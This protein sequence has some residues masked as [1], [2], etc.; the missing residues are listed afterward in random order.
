MQRPAVEVADI[1]RNFGP[2]WLEANRGHVSHAQLKVM[3][4]ILAC[5][6]AA[7]GGFVAI[8]NSRLISADAS[9]V[10]FSYKDYRLEGPEWYTTMTLDPGEFI[11]RF[12]LH[13]LPKGFHRI[14]HYGL[15]ANGGLTRAE[16]IARARQLIGAAPQITPSPQPPQDDPT[17]EDTTLSEE[18]DHPCPHCGSR[19][20]IIEAFQPG[21]RPRHRPSAPVST[22]RINTS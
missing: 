5:R 4:A 15:L 11:R 7:L 14:R 1:F 6:T 9:G 21:C 20:V 2:A 16:K 12:L 8:S 13:V 18:L 3:D 10:T 19:M 22:I 17:Y